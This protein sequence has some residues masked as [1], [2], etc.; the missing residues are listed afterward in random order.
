LESTWIGNYRLEDRLGAGGMG[1]VYRAFDERLERWVALKLLRPDKEAGAL[2][3]QRFRREA[4]AS[5]RLN[6][7]N[8]VQIFD[9]VEVDETDCIVM[10]LVPGETLA[11]RLR[12]GPL[13]IPQILTL[14]QEIAEALAEAHGHGI[15]HRDLKSENVLLTPAGRAKVLDFGIAKQLSRDSAEAS[16]TAAGALLGTCRAMAPEQAKGLAVDSRSDLFS[17]GTLLYE[18]ATGQSPFLAESDLATLQKV[19]FHR[20]LPARR[21]NPEV[22]ESLSA[23]IDWLLE[24]DPAARPQ[25]AAEVAAGLRALA[26]GASWTPPRRDLPGS[27]AGAETRALDPR[28]VRPS[29]A[30]RRHLTV[31]RCVLMGS[32]G[33]ALDPEEL[34]ERMPAIRV[35]AAEVVEHLEGRCGAAL[36]SGLLAWFG[37]PKAHEDDARRAVYAAL[38]LVKRVQGLG[39][40]ALKI[41]IHTGPVVVAQGTG[42][43]GDE[44]VLGEALA[45]AASLQAVA[46]ADTVLLSDS[47]HERIGA[48]FECRQLEPVMPA[49]AAQPVGV[50]QV[51]ADRRVHSH[52]ESAE[53]TRLTPLMGRSQ[54]LLLLQEHWQLAH[55]G[56]GQVVLVCGEA[57]IGKSRLLRELRRE[58]EAAVPS[59]LDC[60]CSPYQSN[61]A[62]YPLIELLDRWIGTGPA[63]ERLTRL[64]E[65]LAGHGLEVLENAPLFAALLAIPVDGR[66]PPLRWSPEAQ[67]KKTLEALLAWLLARA[68]QQPSL[69]VA[70]DLHWIDPS[71]LELLGMLIEQTSAVPL[72]LVLTFRPEFRPPWGQRPLTQLILPA[73]SR[74]QIHAMIERLT[75]GRSLPD[76]VHEEIVE[77]TDGL[78]LFVEE[79]TKMV[80]EAGLAAT[81]DSGSKPAEARRSAAIPTTL[82]GWLLARLDRL[83]TAK[84]VAQW[85]AALGR[86]FSYELLRAV[87]PLDQDV[88]ARE[89]DRLVEA[90]I[91][92]RRG[93][94]PAT[95]YLFKHALLR[96]AAYGSLVRSGRQR[97]HQ[98]IAEIMAASF[99]DIVENQPQILAHHYTEAGL[100]EPAI[101]SWQR[102]GQRAIE[103]SA[104]QEAAGHLKRALDLLS[105]LP[106]SAERDQQELPLLIAL[107]IAQGRSQSFSMP[108]VVE[109]Y[110]RAWELCRRIGQTPQIFPALRGLCAATVTAG[111]IGQAREIATQM[112]ELAEFSGDHSQQVMACQ[113]SG[114]CHLMVGNFSQA[115]ADLEPILREWSP[116]Q[117]S[118]EAQ[119]PGA[120]DPIIEAFANLGLTLWFL[121]FPDA[122]TSSCHQALNLA[123]ELSFPYT[124]GYTALF[125]ATLHALRRE[126]SEV[127]E[128][129]HL[130]QRI[131]EEQTIAIARAQGLFDQGW[132]LA[133]LGQVNEGCQKMEEAVAMRRRFGF[134]A[135]LPQDLSFLAEHYL[136]QGK[137]EEGLASVAEGLELSAAGPQGSAEAE[138]LRLKGELLV[139]AGAPQAEIEEQLQGALDVARRQS[140]KS[141]ELR[142]AMSLAR[143]WNQTGKRHEARE[144]LS[145]IYGWFTEGLETADLRDARALLAELG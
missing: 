29:S 121:G 49:G 105:S 85:A 133:E 122:A 27:W 6:H 120:G 125:K 97:M 80:L 103:S 56:R 99:P 69:L 52:V 113:T 84:E 40:A 7:P 71:T 87:I 45:I 74:L 82:E 60:Y 139:L 127:L 38:E 64:E 95:R 76:S 66:Y 130:L 13:P 35:L 88:L 42:A 108:E 9:I 101:L 61:S 8:I 62:L 144:L 53:E 107:G 25:E 143:L 28:A 10:E 4:R 98:R 109:L 31:L 106:E 129:A 18:A 136:R 141:L 102:A 81:A 32:E 47:T 77:R 145:P 37:Y 67:R 134:L 55:E 132:A 93:V 128:T 12:G 34:F 41:G 39:G 73:L 48:F 22:P 44:L 70:E 118:F 17:F 30:E 79:M 140:A 59:W 11:H 3:R 58:L 116:Q 114:M 51:V 54:E 83:D 142:A 100:K 57:G 75:A 86:E 72:L 1:I 23:L 20:Q 117:P 33:Q 124:T 123:Q 94:P 91:L 63:P 78:P 19:C 2:Q 26:A 43:A 137:A 50:Y 110:A 36:D 89:L 111:A 65:L 115:R 92:Y 46:T 119:N 112:R 131:A 126:P 5:A 96:D 138:L 21:Q 15:V 68:E 90:E 24:K 135:F 16:L 104:N 14:G